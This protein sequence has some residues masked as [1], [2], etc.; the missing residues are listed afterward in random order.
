MGNSTI[1]IIGAGASG[2]MAG[3]ILVKAGYKVTILEARD[4]IGGRIH[5]ITDDQGR[6]IELGAEFIHGDL[7]VTLAL[8][9]EAGIRYE[10]AGGEMWRYQNGSFSQEEEQTEGWEELLDRLQ[11]LDKDIDLSSFLEHHFPGEKYTTLK[12]SVRDFVA[13]YDTADPNKASTFALRKEWANEDE[14]AQH[15]LTNGYCEMVNYLANEIKLYGGAVRLNNVVTSIKWSTGDVIVSTSDHIEYQSD[16]VLIALPLGVLQSEV[17]AGGIK[18]IP[19]IP[20][21][22][23][24]LQDIGFGAIIKILL[25]FKDSFWEKANGVNMK[26]MGFIF[27]EEKIPTW[28]TQAPRHETL[29]TGWLGGPA[30]TDLKMASEDELF[31]IALKS[32]SNI[33]KVSTEILKQNLFSYHIINWTNDPFTFGSYAYDMVGSW[34]ARKVLNKPIN[35]TIFFAGEY[36][37]EGAAM[38]TVEAAL[39]SAKSVVNIILSL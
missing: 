14:D 27:S 3:C 38:G 17:S 16:K 15:R 28:W 23:G 7:P 18:F 8:L 37:Y 30:A 35:N 36:L 5:T 9:K 10:T 2:L 24:A 20:I 26:N 22:K 34:D 33:Y 1:F 21:Q 32:L 4:R 11:K 29:L 12:E 6:K 31:E 19:E 39:T 13:G 25:Q